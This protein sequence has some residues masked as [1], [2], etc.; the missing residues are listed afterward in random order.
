MKQINNTSDVLHNDLCIGCGACVVN[1]S[2]T[3]KFDDNGFYKPFT[4]NESL[5]SSVCPFVDS[6]DNEDALS[7]KFTDGDKLVPRLGNIVSIYCGHVIDDRL[8]SNSTS[9]GMG[10]WIPATLFNSGLIDRVIHVRPTFSTEHPYYKYSISD[11]LSDI[12]ASSAS[13]YY[14]INFRDVMQEVIDDTE[15]NSYC[16]VGIPCFVKALRLLQLEYP[17]LRKKLNFQLL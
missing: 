5:N 7:K 4:Y 8:R 3:I 16:F 10:T 2:N 12:L 13:R 15:D 17:I 11:N 14:P 9:G 1:T 6:N